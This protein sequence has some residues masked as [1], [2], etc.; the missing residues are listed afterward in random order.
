MALADLLWCEKNTPSSL[1]P[2][3]KICH[4]NVLYLTILLR[5]RIETGQV[6]GVECI[7]ESQNGP[8]PGPLPGEGYLPNKVYGGVPLKLVI[9]FP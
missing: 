6:G 5:I 4:L 1:P 7:I 2:P 8:G 3:P 9:F